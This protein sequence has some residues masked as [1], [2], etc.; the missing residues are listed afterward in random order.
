M[1]PP[2]IFDAQ[3]KGWF[4]TAKTSLMATGIPKSGR[5]AKRVF[6]A[7]NWSAASACARASAVSQLR[8]AWIFPSTRAIRSRQDCVTSRAETSRAASLAVN[9]EMVSWLS[10]F[11]TRR[12]RGF[13]R[14]KNRR[15]LRISFHDF[16]DDEKAVGLARCVAE[17]F[18]GR[19]RGSGFVGAGDVDERHG[20]RRRFDVGN[21]ELA[22]FFDIAENV[23]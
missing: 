13:L 12:W 1:N 16:G 3:F 4:L 19:Q 14:F 15:N 6:W 10:I 9:S 23:A 2:R 22:Q 17:R 20:V 21:V 7:S 8:K 18:R 5:P 11:F